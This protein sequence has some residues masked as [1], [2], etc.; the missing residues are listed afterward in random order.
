MSEPVKRRYA[1]EWRTVQARQ[2][3]RVIVA[4]AARLFVDNGFGRTTIGAIAEEAGVS[5]K[6]VFT[7][8]GGKVAVLKLALDWAVAGDDEPATLEQRLAA[9]GAQEGFDF[10]AVLRD[11]VGV[12]SAIGTRVN[13]LSAALFAAAATDDEARD[14]WQSTQ[15]QR[16]AGARAFVA[17]LSANARLRPGLSLDHAADIVWLHSDPAMYRRVVVERGWSSQDFG[18]WL[19]AALKHQLR[20]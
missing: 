6:T 4:A 15:A 9:R 11:W 2:T 19:F 8:V 16:L 18:D 13:G 7:A 1:S 10:D 17:H 12:I 14:L 3:R 5:R 20:G